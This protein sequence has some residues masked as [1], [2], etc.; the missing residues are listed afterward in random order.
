MSLRHDRATLRAPFRKIGATV[1]EGVAARVHGPGDGLRYSPGRRNHLGEPL[2]VFEYRDRDE[3]ARIVKALPGTRMIVKHPDPTKAGGRLTDEPVV[4]R[5]VSARL[6]GNEAVVQFEITNPAG[7]RAITG[8][9]HELSLGYGVGR[10]DDNAFQHGTEIDHLAIV[11]YARCGSACSIRTDCADQV[12]C[13][14]QSAQRMQ[15]ISPQDNKIMATKNPAD[16]TDAL[17]SL[18][19]QRADAESRATTAE[20]SLA[21]ESLRA[22]T[23]EG[24]L[25]ELE[26]QV[27]ELQ[28]QIAAGASA[29]EAEA[30]QREKLRADAAEEKIANFDATY[31]GRVRERVALERQAAIVMG[32]DFR[33]DDLDDRQVMATVVKR[34]DASADVGAAIPDGIIKGRFL[35]LTERHAA[36]A[37][38]LARVA[39]VTATTQRA[40]ARAEAEAKR[41]N[42]W[43]Q[44]LPNA[45][46]ARS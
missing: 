29:A 24:K 22:D 13:P 45:R 31:E 2:P 40:D 4:G 30:V 37:R 19:A 15:L 44:P 20:T 34:L 1:Y 16:Q 21:A 23:A 10:L 36:T 6:D 8:G 33:M 26:K 46:R 18:E 11:E 5:V 41:K 25:L 42:Q 7:V 12:S 9:F 14:C 17:R 28:M 38:S 39:E 3:L 27:E 43:R 32:D 35:A